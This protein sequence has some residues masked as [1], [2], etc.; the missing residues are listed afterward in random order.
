[1]L[2]LVFINSILSFLYVLRIYPLRRY[3]QNTMSS[4]WEM[5]LRIV[6]LPACHTVRLIFV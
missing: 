2:L 4:H 1:M 5:I 6:L 3:S